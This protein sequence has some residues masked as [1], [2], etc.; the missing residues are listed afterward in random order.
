MWNLLRLL[1]LM[2]AHLVPENAECWKTFLTFLQVEE[3]LCSPYF[4]NSDLVVLDS[5]LLDFI[6]PYFEVFEDAKLKPKSH[7]L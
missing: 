3:R 6:K 4:S 7:Y 5:Q 1:P 2:I